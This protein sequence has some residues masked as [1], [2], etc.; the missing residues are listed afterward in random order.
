M[1]GGSGLVAGNVMVGWW[2]RGRLLS[3]SLWGW[4]VAAGARASWR[5]RF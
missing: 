3:V 4:Y 5:C 1:G 2:G